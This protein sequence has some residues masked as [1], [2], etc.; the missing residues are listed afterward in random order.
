MSKRAI[1]IPTLKSGRR[2]R[3]TFE[4]SADVDG[5][6]SARTSGASKKPMRSR[7]KRRTTKTSS[8]RRETPASSPSPAEKPA[9]KTSALATSLAG[10]S[11]ASLTAADPPKPQRAAAR[12]TSHSRMIAIAA[13]AIL[14]IAVLA[15]PRTSALMPGP[16]ADDSRSETSD[17]AEP[18]LAEP[19]A[20]SPAA[21]TARPIAEPDEAIHPE[22]ESAKKTPPEPRPKQV[23]PASIRPPAGSPVVE[24]HDKTLAE[25]PHVNA[26]PT[27]TVI[28]PAPA[29]PTRETDAGPEVTITGC[30]EASANDRFRLTDTEG[31]NAPKARS[32]RSGFLKKRPAAVDLVGAPDV[33]ALQTQ[34]GKRVAITGV[35]TNRELKVNS[36]RL[37]SPSCE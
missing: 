31:A 17:S 7:T 19:S 9:S 2:V 35:Q 28:A 12:G 4:V 14:A 8:P 5:K 13:M 21:P 30:L 11:Q 24:T 15:L 1:R 22:V 33:G 18:I 27:A 16:P 34:V 29:P 32:W 26:A 3:W 23:A 6:K 10:D 25:S 37:V 20:P 36:V